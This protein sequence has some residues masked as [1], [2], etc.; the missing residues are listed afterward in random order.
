MH[1]KN[2]TLIRRA[3]FK[4]PSLHIADHQRRNNPRLFQRD[5][6]VSN[7]AKQGANEAATCREERLESNIDHNAE[8]KES[9]VAGLVAP[10]SA[11]CSNSL[12]EL[13]ENVT[14]NEELKVTDDDDRNAEVDDEQ[15]LAVQKP[16]DVLR[17]GKDKVNGSNDEG[18]NIG[19]D[20]SGVGSVM[21][22]PIFAQKSASETIQK[23]RHPPS[24][25]SLTARSSLSLTRMS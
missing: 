25:S 8:G 1:K 18:S 4:P 16:E 14:R 2:L 17:Q 10:L 11:V 15:D 23:D 24:R 6:Q 13:S 20:P 7:E 19:N 12:A 9:V 22:A 3:K 5:L 21:V